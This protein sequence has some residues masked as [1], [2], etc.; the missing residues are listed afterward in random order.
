MKKDLKTRF[1]VFFYLKKKNF[2]MTMPQINELCR[3]NKK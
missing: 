1:Q 3:E 2:Q